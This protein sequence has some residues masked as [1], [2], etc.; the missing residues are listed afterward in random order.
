MWSEMTTVL[1]GYSSPCFCLSEYRLAPQRLDNFIQWHL[2]RDKGDGT[3]TCALLERYSVCGSKVPSQSA[4]PP[5][6]NDWAASVI[7][8]DRRRAT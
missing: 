3:N 6:I 4:P 5:D 2:L 8:R 7:E 1:E